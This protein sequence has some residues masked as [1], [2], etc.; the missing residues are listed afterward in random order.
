MG[1][2][3][4]DY[5]ITAVHCGDSVMFK[6]FATMVLT[7]IGVAGCAQTTIPDTIVPIRDWTP[8]IS[9]QMMSATLLAKEDVKPDVPDLVPHEDPDKCPCKGTGV[10]V[11]GD[12]H[13]T[14]C[15]FHGNQQGLDDAVK[16]LQDFIDKKEIESIRDLRKLSESELEHLKKLRD[17]AEPRN[18]KCVTDTTRCG[19]IEEYG[20]CECEPEKDSK[21]DKTET[22]RRSRFRLFGGRT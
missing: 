2:L 6:L 21:S 5:R 20:K 17:K 19:C 14:E 22:R 8:L 13:K 12:G 10:I 11:H 16:S 7:G 4:E 15:P 18:C 9:V 1:F 3:H